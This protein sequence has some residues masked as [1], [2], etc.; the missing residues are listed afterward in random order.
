M[1]L[2]CLLTNLGVWRGEFILPKVSSILQP[3]NLGADL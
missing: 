1:P 2:C 3:P